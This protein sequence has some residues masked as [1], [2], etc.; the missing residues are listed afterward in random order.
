MKNLIGTCVDNPFGSVEKLDEVIDNAKPI[1]KAHFFR[2]CNVPQALRADARRFPRDYTF[3]QNGNIMF[4][5]WSR[6]EHFYR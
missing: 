1:S 5:E 6:I 2:S 4:Y 3:Y